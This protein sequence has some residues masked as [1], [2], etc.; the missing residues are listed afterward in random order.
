[1]MFAVMSRCRTWL[2]VGRVV[3]A[4]PGQVVLRQR[5]DDGPRLLALVG[6]TNSKEL[7]HHPTVSPDVQRFEQRAT[8]L[9]DAA[10]QQL[11]QHLPYAGVVIAKG[12][13]FGATQ[14][15]KSPRLEDVD[16]VAVV[17]LME[18]HLALAELAP[19]GRPDD[20]TALVI[21][22]R[23]EQVTRHGSIRSSS[24]RDPLGRATYDE[25]NCSDNA[26]R[27]CWCRSRKARS[28]NRLRRS[29]L[30]T[31]SLHLLVLQLRQAGAMLS[32]V[33]RPPRERA[34][35]QSR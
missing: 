9:L 19:A 21:G 22:E 18:D 31:S 14:P 3:P 30:V 27:I 25:P 16:G 1:M 26:V 29:Q 33:Y 35:T 23:Y 15:R 5:D 34:N 4:I 28:S 8:E 12:D 17:A 11:Q 7:P 20:S 10:R 2:T 24:V 13:E 6:A 32:R